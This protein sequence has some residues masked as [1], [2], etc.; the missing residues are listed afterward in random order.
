MIN[1]I[2]CILL[3]T[4][5]QELQK[6]NYPFNKFLSIINFTV[7]EQDYKNNINKIK[8]MNKFQLNM[9]MNKK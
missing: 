5:K 7:Q 8:M 3:H 9:E 2:S 4:Y 6:K 1:A